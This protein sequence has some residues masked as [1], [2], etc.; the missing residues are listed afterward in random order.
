VEAIDGGVP[1]CLEMSMFVMR[2]G[3]GRV[4]VHTCAS[5]NRHQPLS[6]SM[7]CKCITANGPALGSSP[8]LVIITANRPAA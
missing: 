4:I 2:C 5:Q 8:S 6:L 3:Y 1:R 7:V